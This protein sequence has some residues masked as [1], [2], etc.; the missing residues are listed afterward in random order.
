MVLQTRVE[1]YKYEDMMWVT[2][3]CRAEAVVIKSILRFMRFFSVLFTE[4]YLVAMN[5]ARQFD[6]Y[7]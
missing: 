3:T 4:N 7:R 1:I 6:S 2:V 5:N